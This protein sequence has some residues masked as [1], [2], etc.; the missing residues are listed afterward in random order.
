MPNWCYTDYKVVGEKENLDKLQSILEELESMKKPL[1][2]NGFGVS[3]L[4]NLVVKLGHDWNNIG[5]RGSWTNCER[6]NDTLL[7]LSTKTAWAECNE[8][9]ELIC[10]EFD[11]TMYYLSEEEGMG[12]YETNDT[13]GGYFDGDYK[14]YLEDEGYSFYN[15]LEDLKDKIKEYTMITGIETLE[16]CEE[17]L[18]LYSEEHKDFCAYITKLVRIEN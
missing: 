13:E 10:E 18:N 1:V 14:L 8:V 5:C 16:D 7:S 17:A 15:D 11:V 2:D 6:I 9:R 4:G 3:W 12:I